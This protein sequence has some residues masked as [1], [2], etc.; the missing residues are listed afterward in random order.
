MGRYA[1]DEDA[2]YSTRIYAK[3]NQERT[4]SARHIPIIPNYVDTC[5]NPQASELRLPRDL[6]IPRL[7]RAA[8]IHQLPLPSARERPSLSRTS[9]SAE[10]IE[11]RSAWRGTTCRTGHQRCADPSP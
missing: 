11:F 8:E 5:N 6:A 1:G 2:A 4:G 9:A 10:T 3:T 7:E